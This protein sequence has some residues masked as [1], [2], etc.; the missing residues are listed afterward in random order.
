MN[1]SVGA[2]AK[3]N[4]WL[5]VGALQPSGFH[6]LDTLFCALDLEDTVTL[7]GDAPR[8]SGVRLRIDFEPPLT[9]LPNLGPADRNLAVRAAAGF[10]ES[11][12]IEL[13]VEI[14]LTKRIPPGGGLG[15][16]SSDAAAVLRALDQ[17]YP[18]AVP[19][20]ELRRIAARLGSDVPFFLSGR[21]TALGRGRGTDLDLA[22]ALPSRPVVVVFPSLAVPTAD[23]YR[24]LDEDRA[25]GRVPRPSDRPSPSH[26]ADWAGV[27]ELAN[28]DFEATVFRRHP[29]LQALRDTLLREGASPA[30]LAGSG[31]SLFGVFHDDE[32]ASA[33]M[34]DLA[35]SDV[36]AVLTRTRSR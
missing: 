20:E 24:W 34:R 18:G 23:A 19:G 10:A 5:R 9:A 36:D 30:L 22:P 31:S 32:V 13:D 16:G 4:L 6:D 29:R 35:G 7:R 12:G 26:S 15:G 28:N 11:A 27:Q 14:F 25:A 8:G 3:I 1:V 2:P 21:P 17:V 33:V